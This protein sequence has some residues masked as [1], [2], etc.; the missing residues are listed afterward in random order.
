MLKLIV[1]NNIF[2]WLFVL[3]FLAT[4]V[5]AQEIDYSIDATLN[6]KEKSIEISQQINFTNPGKERTNILY[7]QDWI[8]A[9]R[10]TETPLAK[11]FSEDF[12]RKFYLSSKSKLGFTQ[13][14]TIKG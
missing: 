8:N 13:I 1:S 3:G 2:S 12:N 10:D 6:I 11:R 5:G 7:L 9:Y 14:D 4:N